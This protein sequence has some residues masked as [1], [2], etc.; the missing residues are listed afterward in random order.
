MVD[1]YPEFP[2]GCLIDLGKNRRSE[3]TFSD[4]TLD[5]FERVTRALVAKDLETVDG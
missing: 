3:N 4:A 1:R 5:E 2:G